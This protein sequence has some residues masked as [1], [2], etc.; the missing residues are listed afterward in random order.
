VT[1]RDELRVAKALQG[2][3]FPTDRSA[4]LTYAETR[5]ADAETL[6]ALRAVPDGSYRSVEEVS[7]AVPQEPEGRDR[8]GGVAR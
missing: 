4:L 7:A 8:P 3:G 2:A 6:Q 1:S 5:G